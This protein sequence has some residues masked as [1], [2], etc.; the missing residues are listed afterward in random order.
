MFLT[1]KIVKLIKKKKFVIAT[2]NPNYKTL[3]VHIATLNI[4]FDT[5]IY[6][7]KIAQIAYL[8]ANK[9]LTEVISKYADF[10]EVFSSKLVI[11]LFKYT[12]INNYTIK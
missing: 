10:V 7:S 2:F 9:T 5:K 3:I 1:T 11:K 6:P 8:K 4:S 12:G